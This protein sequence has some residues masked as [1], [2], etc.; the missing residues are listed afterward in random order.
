MEG[1]SVTFTLTVRN[2]GPNTATDVVVDDP[3]PRG[4][5]FIS[6]NPSQ[7][8]FSHA[9][10]LWVV[11]SLADRASA[12]LRL[13]AEVLA[14]GSIVNKADATALQFDPD[15]ANN[16]A[17]AIVTGVGISKRL[18]LASSVPPPPP[19]ALAL[20]ALSTLHSDL[21]FIEDLYQD[22]L[23]QDANTTELEKWLNYLL[24]GGSRVTAAKRILRRTVFAGAK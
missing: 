9:S 2:L 7:G 5:V 20:P 14:F 4:L 8:T 18:F 21:L 6:S 24:L 17:T 22:A 13:T 16:V 23:G 19:P 12:T 3:L 11:G 1:Q 15:L 10:G